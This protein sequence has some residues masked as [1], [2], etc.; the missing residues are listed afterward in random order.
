VLDGLLVDR[1]R[2]SILRRPPAETAEG[3]V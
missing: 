3:D 1:P 2:R